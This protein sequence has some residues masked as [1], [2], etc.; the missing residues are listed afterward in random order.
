MRVHNGA[1]VSY[2]TLSLDTIE[3]IGAVSVSIYYILISYIFML[4]IYGMPV[5]F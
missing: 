1:K 4:Y 5:V 3:Y 2:V